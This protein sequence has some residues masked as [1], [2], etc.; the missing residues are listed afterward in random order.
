MRKL[1]FVTVV[2]LGVVSPPAQA[3]SWYPWDCC[4]GRDC[5]PVDMTEYPKRGGMRL[6]ATID[7][8]KATIDVPRGFLLLPS[9][10]GRAHVCVSRLWER[11]VVRYK[12]LCVFLPGSV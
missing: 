4:H 2:L 7:G 10:D 9:Q 5:A 8:K 1:A 12:P 11:G 6:H 3:H